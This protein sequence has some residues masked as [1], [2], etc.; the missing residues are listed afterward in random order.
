MKAEQI[1]MLRNS[2]ALIDATIQVVNDRLKTD[3]DNQFVV[4]VDNFHAVNDNTQRYG[5]CAYSDAGLYPRKIARRIKR[6]FTFG[7]YK[8]TVWNATG[9]FKVYL[10][11][12]DVRKIE[13][14]EMIKQIENE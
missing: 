1:E 7:V 5:V 14:N 11:K 10:L 6:E 12:L 9:F 2:I 4:Q 8:P 13:I 3:L